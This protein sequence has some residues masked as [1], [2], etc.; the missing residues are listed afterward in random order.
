MYLYNLRSRF[1]FI[2]MS[3]SRLKANFQKKY[4]RNL[5]QP[6]IEEEDKHNNPEITEDTIE[7]ILKA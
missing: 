3:N 4:I 5:D 7:N 2:W 6:G 1:L